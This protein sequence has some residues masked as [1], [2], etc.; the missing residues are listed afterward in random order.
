[1]I[2]YKILTHDRNYSKY[3]TNSFTHSD[4]T[5]FNI[6]AKKFKLFNHDIFTY[7]DDKVTILL[8][9]SVKVLQVYL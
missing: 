9:L 6:D 8:L 2:Q 3:L 5:D 4:V 7:Q 1:M